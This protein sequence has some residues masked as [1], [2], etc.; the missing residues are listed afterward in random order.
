M[1]VRE[2][3]AAVTLRPRVP[4]LPAIGVPSDLLAPAA[5]AGPLDLDAFRAQNGRLRHQRP[6]RT[7]VPPPQHVEQIVEIVRGPR[8]ASSE[9][10][11]RHDRIR[12]VHA[13]PPSVGC[14][15]SDA[16]HRPPSKN[17]APTWLSVRKCAV[18]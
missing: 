1:T 14:T 10:T 4:M 15:H 2:N 11:N 8:M 17:T 7:R 18:L 13:V 5:L 6:R 9:R 3:P 16:S 12:H